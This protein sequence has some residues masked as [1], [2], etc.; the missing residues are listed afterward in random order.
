[1]SWI[2]SWLR[3]HNQLSYI[4][5]VY[6]VEETRSHRRFPQ[7]R[8]TSCLQQAWSS[9]VS[10]V[11]NKTPKESILPD[12]LNIEIYPTG[13]FIVEVAYFWMDFCTIVSVWGAWFDLHGQLPWR[14]VPRENNEFGSQYL[15]FS[16]ETFFDSDQKTIFGETPIVLNPVSGRQSG[17][18]LSAWECWD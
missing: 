18:G 15:D 2:F 14:E 17:C 12:D 8:T 5:Y 9:I 11:K 4:S 16:F 3:R 1:M 7:G 10:L 6:Q 13:W